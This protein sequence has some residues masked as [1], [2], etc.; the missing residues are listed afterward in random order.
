MN[1]TGKQKEH[2]VEPQESRVLHHGVLSADILCV[3]PVSEGGPFCD[4][5]GSE[6]PVTEDKLSS[7]EKAKKQGNEQETLVLLSSMK[8]LTEEE[9]AHLAEIVAVRNGAESSSTELA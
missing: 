8:N 7:G 1:K 3:A 9:V 4:D 5:P 6:L 2:I